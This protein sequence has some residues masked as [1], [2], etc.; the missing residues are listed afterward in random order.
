MRADRLAVLD[1]LDLV[2]VGLDH[3]D[4]SRLAALLADVDQDHRVVAAH[5]LVGEVEASRAEVLDM[6]AGRDPHLE[7]PVD[8]VATETIVAEPGV[9]DARD[10]DLLLHLGQ[11]W[12]LKAL[13]G[14]ASGAR[15]RADRSSRHRL[16]L[17]GEEEQVAAGLPQKVLAGVVVDGDAQVDALVVAPVDPLDRRGAA[18][19]DLVVDVTLGSR[20]QDDLVPQPDRRARGGDLAFSP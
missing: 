20:P 11:L 15:V 9:A 17:V 10:Q 2:R 7:Q 1:R 13:P 14:P 3:V 12:L 8:H 5:H 6:D 18:V 19:E 16:D 4:V